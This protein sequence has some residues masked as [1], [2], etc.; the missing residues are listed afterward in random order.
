M[1][2]IVENKLATFSNLTLDKLQAMDDLITQYI[3]FFKKV[4]HGHRPISAGQEKL[5]FPCVMIEPTMDRQ[6]MITTAKTEWK[7]TYELW[8]YIV[9]NSRDG[10]VEQQTSAMNALLKLFSNNAKGDLLTASKSDNFKIYSTFWYD[11]E[12]RNIQYSPTFSFQW[13]D[14]AAYCR[15]GRFTIELSDRLIR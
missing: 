11:S 6:E 4:Y 2:A 12:I 7:G 3:G 13:A 15:A 10:L 9:N 8:F 5:I 1:P 14:K